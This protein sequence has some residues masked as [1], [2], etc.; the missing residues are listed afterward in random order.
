MAFLHKKLCESELDL[1]TVRPTQ[2][3]QH[4]RQSHGAALIYVLS[5]VGWTDRVRDIRI[6]RRLPGPRQHDG[7]RSIPWIRWITG[8]IC[9]SVRSTST[10]T[11]HSWHRRPTRIRT[12]PTPIRCW[13]TDDDAMKD[14]VNCGTRTRP[15]VWTQMRSSQETLA[16][17]FDETTSFG[18]AWSIWWVV[19]T[20][21]FSQRR[22]RRRCQNTTVTQL[23]RVRSHDLWNRPRFQNQ[24]R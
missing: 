3:G 5:L 20:W 21:I 15:I 14:E 10:W 7:A 4:R 8:F 18:V 17:W 11:E 19:S 1:F 2:S 16:S 6:W 12:A 23:E 22:Q 24:D 9:S 13:V